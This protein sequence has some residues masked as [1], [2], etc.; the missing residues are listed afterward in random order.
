MVNGARG[1]LVLL[2]SKFSDTLMSH[3]ADD[4]RENEITTFY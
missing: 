3:F 1:L 2:L 4:S